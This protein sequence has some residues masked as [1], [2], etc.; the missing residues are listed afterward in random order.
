MLRGRDDLATIRIR[1]VE[2]TAN[3]ALV[4]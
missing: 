1:D 4:W 3:L 2:T